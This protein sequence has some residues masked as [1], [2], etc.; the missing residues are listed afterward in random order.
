MATKT[1][2]A[3]QR[4]KRSQT[5][6]LVLLAGAGATALVLTQVDPS[7]R[8]ED[9]LVYPNPEA[10]AAGRVRTEADCRRDYATARATYPESAP[11][12]PNLT[13]CEAHHGANHCVTGAIVTASATGQFVPIMAAFL[14]G[15]RSEQDLAPQPVYDHRPDEAAQ[16]F[17]GGG[18]GYCTGWGGRVVTSA[19]GTSSSARVASSAVRRASFGGFGSTGRGFSAHGGG[20]SHGSGG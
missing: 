19:G 10:C 7:Q 12:Y 5:V 16:G 18:G 6:T 14:L 8:E 3:P 1:E 13:A 4:S 11:R 2:P 9:V 20:S 15:R 17:H